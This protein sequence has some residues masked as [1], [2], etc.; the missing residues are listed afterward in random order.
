MKKPS[1]CLTVI[2]GVLLLLSLLTARGAADAAEDNDE[3][4]TYSPP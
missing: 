4:L 3:T 1:V 2:L